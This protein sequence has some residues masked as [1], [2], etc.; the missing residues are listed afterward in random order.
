MISMHLHGHMISMH[1]HGHMISMHL[2]GHMINMHLHRYINMH[3]HGHMISMHLQDFTSGRQGFMALSV[4][5]SC[6]KGENGRL[7]HVVMY[8]GTVDRAVGCERISWMRIGL[9]WKWPLWKLYDLRCCRLW[10]TL[11]YQRLCATMSIYSMTERGCMVHKNKKD[12]KQKTLLYDRD[13]V[14]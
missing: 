3:L 14:I 12:C 11:R 9:R 10:T 2:H 7:L 13:I 5:L 1:L 4:I 8:N 6:W